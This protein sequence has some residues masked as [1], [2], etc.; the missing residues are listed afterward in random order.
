MPYVLGMTIGNGVTRA[1]LS[2]RHR[3]GWGET[4]LVRLGTGTA[5]AP[6]VVHLD[7]DGSAIGGPGPQPLSGFL[8]RV[9]D[10]VPMVLDGRPYRAAELVAE[11]T[12]WVVDRVADA[13]GGP[14]ERLVLVVPGS[15]GPH[16]RDLVDEALWRAGLDEV[17]LLAEPLAAAEAYAAIEPVEPGDLL[18]VYSHGATTGECAI[19]RRT[20]GT[21]FEALAGTELDVGLS[22]ADLDDLLSDAVDADRAA[23][24]AAKEKLSLTAEV[25]VSAELTLTRQRFEELVGPALDAAVS[26]LPATLDA[27]GITAQELAA[28]LLVGGT[29]RIPL[30]R[31]LIQAAVPAPVPTGIDPLYGVVDGAVHV[32]RSLATGTARVPAP[33][34]PPDD[35]AADLLPRPPRPPVV[36]TPLDPPRRGTARHVARRT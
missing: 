13:E 3:T 25:P 12:G 33:R 23:L 24:R 17:T 6:S 5:A 19:V 4:E 30:L 31:R 34:T 22:G 18:A 14:P 1:G 26:A 8:H 11:L 36:I 29:T 9:G 7:S 21:A 16:R 28:V 2:R 15:W 35:R 20:R 10:D 27:A 32:A